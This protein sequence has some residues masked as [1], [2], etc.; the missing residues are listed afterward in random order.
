MNAGGETYL[1]SFVS[2]VSVMNALSD[3]GLGSRLVLEESV[4]G[5]MADGAAEAIEGNLEGLLFFDL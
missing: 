2:V 4:G 1:V 5:I 3:G